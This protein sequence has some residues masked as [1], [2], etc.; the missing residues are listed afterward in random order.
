MI[1]LD[2]QINVRGIRIN[3]YMQH[4][5]QNAMILRRRGWC[6]LNGEKL[7]SNHNNTTQQFGKFFHPNHLLREEINGTNSSEW[8]KGDG[9]T[10]PN[11]GKNI[12]VIKE[13]L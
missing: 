2:T 8:V 9:G 3:S 1:D 4:H 5:D 6:R 7:Q 12:K 13:K 11:K 10:N